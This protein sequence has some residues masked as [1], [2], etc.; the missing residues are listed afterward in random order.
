[1]FGFGS[2]DQA[3]DGMPQ[4]G[5]GPK[6]PKLLRARMREALDLILRCWNAD[7]PFDYEG[8]FWQG[9]GIHPT[10]KP[11]QSP[12]SRVAVGGCRGLSRSLTT[13]TVRARV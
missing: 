7:E 6:N 12:S 1:M 13:R 3:I 4:R 2:G 9:K 5:L 10:V 8:A 11:Y